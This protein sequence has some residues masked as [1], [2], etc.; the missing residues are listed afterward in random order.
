M[1]K[2][3]LFMMTLFLLTGCDN[4]Q[5]KTEQTILNPVQTISEVSKGTYNLENMFAGS[6]ITIEFDKNGRVSGYSG[7]NRYFGKADIKNGKILIDSLSSTKLTGTRENMKK[8]ERYL[9]MLKNAS[10]IEKENEKIIIT[11]MLG[12][13]LIF[14]NQ[15]K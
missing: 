13:K 9:N 4:L 2:I 14:V 5:L 1:K 7:L 3:V 15:G 11:D 10:K 12:A 6:N 8:E